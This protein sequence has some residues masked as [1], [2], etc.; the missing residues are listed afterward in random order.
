[1]VFQRDFLSAAS[2]IELRLLEVLSVG[3]HEV[4]PA[5]RVR[6]ASISVFPVVANAP[7]IVSLLADEF[8]ISAVVGG[9][10]AV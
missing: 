10:G 6:V 8:V 2:L 3:S 9:L 1:M 4:K 5:L 7:L